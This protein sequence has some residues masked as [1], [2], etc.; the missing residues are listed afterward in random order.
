MQ[1]TTYSYLVN[2]VASYI[3]NGV[4]PLLHQ[5]ACFASF[6]ICQ[7]V[8]ITTVIASSYNESMECILHEK[9]MCF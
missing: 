9:K 7:L 1:L 4:E 2:Y 5:V 8:I 3:A 6:M